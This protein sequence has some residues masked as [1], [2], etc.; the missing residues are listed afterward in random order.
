MG[1]RLHV[2]LLLLAAAFVGDLFLASRAEA[3]QKGEKQAANPYLEHVAK[4]HEVKVLLERA[5]HDYKGH[6]A[7]AVKE[8]TA[9]IHTLHP[10]HKPATGKGGKGGNN[11]PQALSDAQLKQSIKD[12]ETIQGHLDRAAT[13]PAAKASASL[14]K[15]MKELNIALEIK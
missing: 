7:A 4:L 2:F 5:D 15:A 8:I 13:A 12:L 10:H 14:G 6:R 11:E 9:A 3:R 1:P